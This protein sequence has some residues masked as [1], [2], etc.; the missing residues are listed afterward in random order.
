[1]IVPENG[2][3][4]SAA[5]EEAAMPGMERRS[6]RRSGG[7]RRR[8]GESSVLDRQRPFGQIVNPFPPVNPMTPEQLAKVHDVSMRILEE[9]GIEVMSADARRRLKAAG[10]GTDEASGI[11]RMDRALVAELV[12]KAPERFTLTPWNPERA[13]TIGGNVLN[14]GMVSGPPNV[15][16]ALRGRRPGNFAD[17]R[18]LMK[19]AQ[20]F[21]VITMF[22]NQTLA[23]TDLPANTRHL[24]TYLANLTLTDKMFCGMSIGSGRVRDLMQMQAIARGLTV[25]DLAAS[26]SAITNI[27]V[28]SPRKLDKEMSDAATALAEMGQAVIVTP[29]TLMG[30]MTPVTLPAALAQQNAEALLTIALIQ[31]VRPGAPV[32]YGCFTSNVDMRTGAPAF[33]TPEN[34]W[35]NLAGGQLARHYRLP[36]RT[37]SCNASNVADAQAVYETEMALWGAVMGHGNM[38]YHAAGWLEGGL[39]ASFEKLVIDVEILQNMAAFLEPV[40]FSD[41]EFAFE[42]IRET[43]P[44]GH[45]FGAA[46]TMERFKTAFYEPMVSDWQNHENWELAG[47]LDASSRA[48][49]I[50]QQVLE[51]YEPPPLDPGRL[52]ALEAYVARRKEEIGSGEP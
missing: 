46:H 40:D 37:S 38:I 50:W 11:V 43:A 33:G 47:A 19:L 24:D 26:P 23:P 42:A 5:R 16:D 30:A 51:R 22:G 13:V 49:E 27:N 14:F 4:P 45:F 25:E 15:H 35:A 48:T 21:N 1:M 18:E 32:V 3:G 31:T 2:G 44:G 34:A 17:Y 9:I 6:G 39:V 41:T 28:N 20:S 29:F 10:A 52:E 12:A 8:G 7:G 36:Y